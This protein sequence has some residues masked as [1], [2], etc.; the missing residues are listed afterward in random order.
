[1][2][3][4]RL[5]NK[6]AIVTGANQGIGRG[7]CEYFHAQGAFLV[8]A[9]IRQSS[10]NGHSPDDI[11]T[12]EWINGRG[13]RAI[14]VQVDVSKPEDTERMVAT[15]VAKYGRVDM[16]VLLARESAMSWQQSNVANRIQALSIMPVFSLS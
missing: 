5:Q 14:F 4:L 1:M 8:C 9:D 16:Y 6:V 7:V 2:A 10:A 12:H 15:A 3:G 13:G 11:P